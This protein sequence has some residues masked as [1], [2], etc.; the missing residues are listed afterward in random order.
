LQLAEK[1]PQLYDIR[2]AH[3]RVMK[4]MK[5]PDI[6]K[7]MPNPQGSVESNPALENVQMT[8]G[9]PAAAFPDQ[10]HIDH[11]KVHLAYMMDPAYGG[12]ALIGPT[13]TPLMLEH[14]KQHLT[15]HLQLLLRQHLSPYQP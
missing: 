6:D 12:N 13:V 10:S 3:M 11:I 4:L 14:I 2:E 9:H 7:V 1:A 8:M 5:V 15:L